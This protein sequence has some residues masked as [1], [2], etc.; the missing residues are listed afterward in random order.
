MKKLGFP[1]LMMLISIVLWLVFYNK[2]PDQMPM[3]WGVD[4]SVN[5]YAP[6]FVAFLVFNGALLFL[7]LTIYIAPK[8]D[9]KKKNYNQFSR[10]YTILM[11][12]FLIL[13]FFINIIVV[14]ISLD[15]NL[16][17]NVLAPVLAGITFVISGNYMQTLK[18]NWFVGIRTPWTVDHEEVWRRT[19]RLGARIMIVAGFSLCTVIPF[20]PEYLM[21]PF[22]IGIIIIIT[23]IPTIYSYVVHRNIVNK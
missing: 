15:Y 12:M 17:M 5:W 10:S 3:Q 11:H 6:K 13:F 23:L 8:I 21:L 22:I 2:L 19:H 7:Y 9:P 18:P 20:L 1:L 16:R 14:L 4:G